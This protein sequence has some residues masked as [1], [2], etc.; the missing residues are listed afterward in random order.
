MIRFQ[1][2]NLEDVLGLVRAV[3]NVGSS[4]SSLVIVNRR[5]TAER[6]RTQPRHIQH[7]TDAETVGGDKKRTLTAVVE[8]GAEDIAQL[9]DVEIIDLA[10]LAW[11]S[12]PTSRFGWTIPQSFFPLR[13]KQSMA[14]VLSFQIFI[15]SKPRRR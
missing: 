13:S 14:S 3:D 8:P 2:A 10:P 11:T 4:I 7:G 6:S 9:R 1:S 5:L 12:L 15:P